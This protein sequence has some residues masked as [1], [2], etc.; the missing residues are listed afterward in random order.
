MKE[1]SMDDYLVSALA[2]AGD[3]RKDLKKTFF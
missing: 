1:D 3:G 2:Y